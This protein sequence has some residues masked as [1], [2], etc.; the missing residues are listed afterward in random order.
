VLNNDGASHSR[1]DIIKVPSYDPVGNVV[2]Q[3]PIGCV[4]VFA[5]HFT[6]YLFVSSGPLTS[7]REVLPLAKERPLGPECLTAV[8]PTEDGNDYP[9]TCSNGDVNV[10]AWDS[11]AQLLP[12][13][14][15]LGR[16][17]TRCQVYEAE[18]APALSSEENL[19]YPE[20]YASY[21][22]ASDYYGWNFHVAYPTSSKT[23]WQKRCTTSH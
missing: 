9:L 7:D 1:L 20:T 6:T 11:Y 5:G 21:Q 13:L 12:R 15:T 18:V 3:W 14:F 23:S 22:L 2:S 4:A 10:A 8:T 17:A 16:T 19:T